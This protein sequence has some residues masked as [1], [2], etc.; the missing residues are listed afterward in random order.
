MKKLEA[1]LEKLKYN[2]ICGETDIE[3]NGLK[4]DSR[5]IT[6]G[7]VFVCIHGAKFDGHNYIREVIKNGAK[8]V[9]I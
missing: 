1:L 4:M 2:V 9:I 7:D 6:D 3:I 8:A 5:N